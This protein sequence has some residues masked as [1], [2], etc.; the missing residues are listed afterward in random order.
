M[1]VYTIGFTKKSAEEFFGA[2]Q[3][4]GVRRIVDVR[5]N[6]VSQLAGFTKRDD[7]R[8]LLKAIAGI[9]YV[10]MLDLAPEKHQLDEYKKGRMTWQDYES[11]YLTLL[12]ARNLADSVLQ[13]IEDGDCLLCSEDQPAKCHRRLAAEYLARNRS[14][15][16]VMHLG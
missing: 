15:V 8:Y 6:N 12:D 1:R 14:G 9:N 5:L 7:L 13:G 4:A 3:R 2:I 11:A 10:H 16:D